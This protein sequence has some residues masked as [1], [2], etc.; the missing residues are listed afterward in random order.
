MM[1]SIGTFVILAVNGVLIP[2]VLGVSDYGQYAAVVALIG[3]WMLASGVGFSRVVV[4][5]LSPLWQQGLKRESECFVSATLTGSAIISCVVAFGLF[6]WFS[7]VTTE[8]HWWVMWVALFA[9]TRLFLESTRV[10][11]TPIGQASSGVILDLIRS[12]GSLLVVCVAYLWAG[13][14]AVFWALSLF[15]AL[16]VVWSYRMLRRL[17]EVSLDLRQLGLLKPYLS[18][19]AMGHV[20]TLSSALRDSLSVYLVALLCDVKMAGH[21]AIAVTL[22]SSI[23]AIWQ[24]VFRGVLPVMSELVASA[25]LTRLRMWLDTMNRVSAAGASILFL[26]WLAIGRDF[27][28]L[29]LGTEFAP[30]FA[31]VAIYLASVPFQIAVLINNGLF[32]IQARGRAIAVLSGIQLVMT[33]LFYGIIWLILERH[34]AATAIVVVNALV[35]VISL[36]IVVIGLRRDEI[37]LSI[38]PF[39]LIVSSNL[40]GFSVYLFLDSMVMRV[41]GLMGVALLFGVFAVRFRWISLVACRS[42]IAIFF[43]R[44]NTPR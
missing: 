15:F 43:F 33:L 23:R 22:V 30:V 24:N 17:M 4:L 31:F 44:K 26:G 13:V 27:V 16:L 29:L 34:Q 8:S 35:P 11:F 12:A 40:A 1:G 39:L 20:G 2:R 9:L 14:D 25:Q 19:L 37:R 41:L 5:R 36:M 32:N 21:I 6:L 7:R 38:T 28:A 18:F 42:M 10:L 3:F